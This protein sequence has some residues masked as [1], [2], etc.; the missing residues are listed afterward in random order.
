MDCPRCKPGKRRSAAAQYSPF[1]AA[2]NCAYIPGVNRLTRQEQL[3][4]CSV[5]GLLLVGLA[6]KTYRASHPKTVAIAP[7]NAVVATNAAAGPR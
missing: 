7:E 3:V 6:V 5:L 1:I 4:L 2:G